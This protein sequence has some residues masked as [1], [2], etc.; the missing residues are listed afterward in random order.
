MCQLARACHVVETALGLR[1]RPSGCWAS[2]PPAEGQQ[3]QLLCT[4]LLEVVA[5]CLGCVPHCSLYCRA[6]SPKQRRQGWGQGAQAS[7][8]ST[9]TIRSSSSNSNNKQQA[10]VR[11]RNKARRPPC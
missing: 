4:A 8:R 1:A 11:C 9:K 10:H 3:G 2:G 6:I 7:L 5:A